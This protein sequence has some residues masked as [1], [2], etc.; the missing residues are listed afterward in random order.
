MRRY[1]PFD[2]DIVFYYNTA[3]SQNSSYIYLSQL[4]KG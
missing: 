2:I 3:G 1:P 4:R